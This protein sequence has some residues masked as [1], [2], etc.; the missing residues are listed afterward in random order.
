MPD[1][2]PL[3]N[4]VECQSG[5]MTIRDLDFEA[6]NNIIDFCY[7]GEITI[8]QVPLGAKA[9]GLPLRGQGLWVT[10]QGP[11]LVGKLSVL[12]SFPVYNFL[13]VVQFCFLSI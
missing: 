8:S 5:S 1:P 4:M 6:V 11:R 12:L 13:S 10:P 7:T 9:C 2:P 3:S